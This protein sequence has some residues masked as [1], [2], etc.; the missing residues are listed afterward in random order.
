MKN[1]SLQSGEDVR[2]LKGNGYLF[3]ANA[4]LFWLGL[5]LHPKQTIS[6]LLSFVVPRP[7]REGTRRPVNGRGK[8]EQHVVAIHSGAL[9]RSSV[10]A[11]RTKGFSF[12]L[13]PFSIYKF[14]S[15]L[16]I[17]SKTWH[18]MER[19]CEIFA[20]SIPDMCIYMYIM[21]NRIHNSPQNDK[22]EFSSE[23]MK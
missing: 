4:S 11:A 9:L 1:C 23:I 8:M 6:S 18:L 7:G 19:S 16:L 10:E 21:I 22:V 2:F 3:S 20:N 13:S 14:S 15:L 17:Q 5:K 12:I